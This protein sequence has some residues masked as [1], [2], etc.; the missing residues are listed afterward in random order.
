MRT[1]IH[2]NEVPRSKLRGASLK[3]C[4]GL[5]SLVLGKLI[6]NEPILNGYRQKVGASCH[7]CCFL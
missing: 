6:L 1:G 3:K 5:L 4:T 2:N 7:R